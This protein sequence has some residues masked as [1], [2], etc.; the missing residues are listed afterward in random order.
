[1]GALIVGDIG[2]YE[3]GRAIIIHNQTGKLQR[4]NKLHLSYMALQYPLLFSYGED[5]YRIDISWNPNFVG[6]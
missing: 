6:K 3:D 5:E 2:Q 1:M 4:I